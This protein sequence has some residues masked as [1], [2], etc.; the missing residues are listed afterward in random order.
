LEKGFTIV[1]EDGGLL[2]EICGAN[3]GNLKAMEDLL[4]ARVLS[5]GNEMLVESDD[6][7]IQ[8][9][10]VALVERLAD[11]AREGRA[12]SIESIHALH[13]GLTGGPDSERLFE[14]AF[15]QIP[16]GFG[17]IFPR[18]LNQARYIKGMME[19]DVT[20]CVG[21]AGTGK[22]FLA[23]AYA[24]REVATKSKRKLV[25]TRPVVEAGE[26]LGFLPGDLIQKINPYLRPLYDA[27]DSLVPGDLIRKLEDGRVIEIAPLAYM[28]GRSLN[29][30]III[31]D[32]A[33]NTTK[34]QMKM[35]LTRIGQGSK[36]IV[37]GDTT[38]IDLPK[39]QESGLV[40]ALGLL[41]GIED[42]H[43]SRLEAK[44]VVRHPL[45]R[46]IIK[47]YDEER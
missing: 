15:I 21:P 47:A 22:T 33:Q 32:E 10:F 14:D 13:E 2:S 41:A 39:K 12:P 20:F 5:R 6:E 11:S 31:L 44:D 36:A 1:L 28:R 23:V 8:A 9:T 27:M 25:L 35:F 42:I 18:S 34:E 37:T 3:D 40:H 38:Q 46:K 24:L 43:F 26:S 45:I 30:A 29:D 4:G 19:K 7:E 17:R 16:A